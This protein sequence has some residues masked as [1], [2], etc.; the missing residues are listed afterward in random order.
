MSYT[1]T[2]WQ[3]GRAGGTEFTAARMNNIEQGLVDLFA[4]GGP[5]KIQNFAATSVLNVTG[6]DG[7]THRG[8]DL[9]L[10]W[11]Y[12]NT[13]VSENAPWISTPSGVSMSGVGSVGPDTRWD[14]AGAF[15]NGGFDTTRGG[16]GISLG[17]TNGAA[18]GRCRT[19]VSGKVMCSQQD[20]GT[21][22]REFI[23]EGFV[24]HRAPMGSGDK[25]ARGGYAFGY[26]E[27]TV[28]LTAFDVHFDNAVAS[29]R[30]IL[31]PIVG[32]F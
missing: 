6:L 8:Y 19:L 29:G 31:R 21:S 30:L 13:S 32:S 7:D 4:Y 16:S 15:T 11:L 9:W 22:T 28:N 23:F 26:Y 3:P 20:P 2:T 25:R 10:D 12:D 27:Q 24:F 14:A 17:T 1:R 5:P 18:T